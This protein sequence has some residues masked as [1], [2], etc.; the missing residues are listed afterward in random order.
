MKKETKKT[1]K[2]L[3]QLLE[4][5]VAKE[6]ATGITSEKINPLFFDYTKLKYQPEPL[7]RLD[8][9][10]HRYYYRLDQ[11][12]NPIFYT[13]VTTMIK[14]T[15]PTSPHL[16]KW[17]VDKQ[18]DGK[19]EAEER[20]NYGTFLHA[21]LASLLM[22]GT[23]DLDKLPEILQAFCTRENIPYKAEWASE[24]KKDLLAL[25]QFII[26]HNVKPLAIEICLWH[27]EDE[28]AGAIDLGCEMDVEDKGYFGE[29]YATGERKGQPK[30]SK[31]VNRIR[32]IVDLKSG[33][34]GFYESHEVQLAAYREMW[35][36][37]FPDMRIDRVFNVSPKEWRSTPSYN[38]TEQTDKKS[39][40][41]LPHLIQLAKIE[42]SRRS[43][44]VTV[45][46]GK[47]ELTKGLE[48]NIKE[49][50]FTDLIKR[51]A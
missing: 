29:V 23:Y 16:I 49:L 20:A 9:S 38:L 32:A 7:Y 22:N 18:G 30:E 25:S 8:S 44:M 41:K 6:L 5:T 19:D 27:P 14:N 26:D 50:S 28:Y 4:I 42:D 3:S 21:E 13:S 34:K 35:N 43:N 51:G 45:C 11:D 36:I 48:Q 2:K 46:E 33:R 31:Q 1:N 37:H 10:G 40:A 15:M 17:L 47:I 24:L 39:I 12:N